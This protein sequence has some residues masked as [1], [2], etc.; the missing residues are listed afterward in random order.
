VGAACPEAKPQPVGRGGVKWIALFGKDIPAGTRLPREARRAWFLS[1]R[2]YLY[3]HHEGGDDPGRFVI[4]EG[5][6]ALGIPNYD[7]RL[8]ERCVADLERGTDT[9]RAARLLTRYTDEQ[10]AQPAEWRRWLDENEQKLFF[11]DTAGY[12]F[13]LAS[14]A[15]ARA[16][17]A[18]RRDNAAQAVGFE[19]YEYGP[20]E[21][22]TIS[23]TLKV[24]IAPGFHVYAP[25]TKQAGMMV[26]ALRLPKDSPFTFVEGPAIPTP[27]GGSIS[28]HFTV[29][30]KLKGAGKRVT[31][32]VDYQACTERFCLPPVAGKEVSFDVRKR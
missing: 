25:N 7:P 17:S 24:K 27:A 32:L 22:G 5:A 10:F 14:A 23:R 20:R 2:P 26:F 29:P 13:R 19:T 1:V 11:S 6:R 30:L 3:H 31:V 21:A 18:S 8:L 9:E 12:K 16:A 4:D 28:G 15:S